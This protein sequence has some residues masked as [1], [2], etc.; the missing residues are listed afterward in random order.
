[1][2]K[3]LLKYG[4]TI[5]FVVGFLV[6]LVIIATT[7]S[8]AAGM[9]PDDFEALGQVGAF[10]TAVLLAVIFIIVAI[11]AILL[12]GLYGLISNP[13]SALKFV[14]GLV[15]LAV[16]LGITYAV[17]SDDSTGD[18]AQLVQEYDIQGTISRMISGGLLLTV[19]LLLVGFASILLAE[20]R[21]IFK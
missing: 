21:N 7:T 12:G 14:I 16:L 18:L 10:Q 15:G 2:Y 6:A 9:R 3:T 4:T 20:I 5:A 19:I 13:K 11:I 1:M 8:G 17:S